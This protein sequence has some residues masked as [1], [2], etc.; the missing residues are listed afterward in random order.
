MMW[1]V[2]PVSTI[3]VVGWPPTR[4]S[5]RGGEAASMRSSKRTLAVRSELGLGAG[6]AAGSTV[7]VAA[8]A[9]TGGAAVIAAGE[10]RGGSCGGD[11]GEGRQA[12]SARE[13]ASVT[14][15]IEATRIHESTR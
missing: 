4:A 6:G 1:W 5:T 7:V 8:G 10:G 15:G 3:S 9:A 12:P 2:A 14:T 13:Q 11:G